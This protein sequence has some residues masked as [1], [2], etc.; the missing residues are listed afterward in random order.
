M[1]LSFST[2]GKPD[3]QNMFCYLMARWSTLWQHNRKEI[4]KSAVLIWAMK[5]HKAVNLECIC[6]NDWFKKN[7]LDFCVLLILIDLH[8]QIGHNIMFETNQITKKKKNT[9]WGMMSLR[10]LWQLQQYFTI[11]KKTQYFYKNGYCIL[12][13]EFL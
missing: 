11:F 13:Y 8:Y 3:F 7:F 12:I 10:K 9:F 6:L 5:V 4:K 2:K 1:F